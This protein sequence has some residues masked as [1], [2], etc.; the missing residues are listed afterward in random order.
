MNGRSPVLPNGMTHRSRRLGAGVVLALLAGMASGQEVGS[1]VLEPVPPDEVL[2]A[3]GAVIGHVWI[4]RLNIFDPTDPE[5]SGGLYSAANALHMITRQSTIRAQLLFRGGE[6]YSRRLLDESERI[7]RDN[8]YLWDAWIEPVRYESGVV[9]VRVTTR[10]VWTIEP[11]ISISRSGGKSRTGIE[12]VDQNFLGRGGELSIGRKQDED[13][14]STIFGYSDKNLGAS[15]LSLGVTYIDSSDGETRGLYLR[16]PFFSLNT[17]WSAGG[18]VL[19]DDRVDG[20]YE[21]GDKIGEYRHQTTYLDGFYGWSEGLQ[22]GWVN[23]WRVGVVFDDQSFEQDPGGK[24]SPF[25]PGDRKL[26]YPYMTYELIEDR[27]FEA[28]NLNQ[29]AR[30][31]DIYL[32][33]R[34]SVTLGW[35]GEALGAD[36]DSLIF[37]GRVGR[38]YGDPGSQFLSLAAEVSGR[39]DSDDLVNTVLSADARYYLHQTEKRTFYAGLAVDGGRNLDLDNPL[40]IGG[41]TG[42]RGYPLRYQR[43]EGRVLA[44]L[45]QRF[46]TDIYLLRILRVGGAIFYDMGRTWGDNP[47]GEDSL[48]W[49]KDVGFGLRLGNT[50]TSIGKVIHIDVAFPLDGDDDIDSVQI[51]LEGK[52]SF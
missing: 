20:V 2:E 22:D 27:F 3:E 45:E 21:L 25:I 49:L 51:L 23:R 14:D 4:E 6:K 28:R 1:R 37:R 19:D 26:V 9:D 24:I 35:S 12:V 41:D 5:E 31:E 48:G 30:T 29:M 13:R 46:Y 18:A 42:L 50:R 40:E 7:L 43:G 17:R 32:G 44:T 16:R 34:A 38:G 39:M 15:W 33:R 8:E 11:G 52:R 47:A 36:R 10:D